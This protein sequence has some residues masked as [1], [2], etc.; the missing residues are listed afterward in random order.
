MIELS[1][2]M[3]GREYKVVRNDGTEVIGECIEYIPDKDNEPEVDCIWIKNLEGAIEEI[4][5]S[6]ITD[7]ERMP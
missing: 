6:D 7:V 4:Y 5:I 1:E 3:V 2:H